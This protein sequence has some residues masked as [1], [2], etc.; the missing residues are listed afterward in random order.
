M[1]DTTRI[2]FVTWDGP[3]S[4][5]LESLFLPIF[6]N[7]MRRGISFHVIQFTWS[8]QSERLALKVA[9]E[10][11]GIGY[12]SIPVLRRPLSV[13][14]LATAFFGARHIRRAIKE[15]AIDIV[16]PRSTLPAMAAIWALKSS[17]GVGLVF[18]ADGLPHDERIDFG[19]LSPDSIAY[20][21][22]R[23]FEALAVR[24]ADVVLTRSKM[25][26]DTLVARG[27][28]GTD[29]RKFFV[30]TNGRDPAL[31]L[32]ATQD[33]R[34]A[35]KKSLGI[36]DGA[37]L[38]VHVGSSMHGKYGG[39]EVF[40]FFRAVHAKRK[41]ARLILLSSSP[42]EAGMLLDE[43]GELRPHCDII[44]L[45]P[46]AVAGFLGVCDLGLVFIHRK[47]SMQAVAPI[48]LGEYLLC[49]VPVLATAGIGDA[50]AISPDA[51]MLVQ[52][53]GAV[54]LERAAA[55]FIDSVLPQREKYRV[56]SRAVGLNRFSLEASAVSYQNALQHL[57]RDL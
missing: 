46:G 1:S 36:D 25:A 31:F 45:R 38:V 33:D 51:G 15:L 7:L 47:F 32:P 26:C 18:D 39:R 2:L 54:E 34:I 17:P 28:A 21:L 53:M 22:L 43:Y 13:G 27:G 35:V 6:K 9:L 16:M 4:T 19:G 11:E 57:N 5:Y 23:D 14:S 40:E 42:A 49:G 55:W 50:E 44:Q 52:G 3:R 41:D 48:K 24:R 30:V 56:S 29:G 8:D 12:R 20:R 10:R 37:P